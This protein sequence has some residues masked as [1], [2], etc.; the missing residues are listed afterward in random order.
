M[1][2]IHILPTDKPSR[3]A[4]S[5]DKLL[6]NSRPLSSIMYKNQ[7]IYI[8]NDEE[9]KE[10][11]TGYAYKEDVQGKVFKHFYTTNTWYKDAKKIILTTDQDLIKDGVQPIPDDFLEW[12]VKNPSCEEVQIDD[13]TDYNYQPDYKFYS[14]IIPKEEHYLSTPKPL[15]DVS[16]MK[17]DNHPDKQE[18]LEEAAVRYEK[19]DFK[20]KPTVE[21]A[22]MMIQRAFLNGAKWQQKQDKKL[23]SE[24]EV[25]SIQ[26]IS[27][28]F[29]P[30]GKGGYID[31]YLD[32]RLFSKEQPKLNF[33]EWFEQFKKKQ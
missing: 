6:L 23:Y 2:N 9:I 16:R 17:L 25:Y 26:Q 4:M 15:I 22:Q 3:L 7:N 32:Y 21:S 12:F 31:D 8:T 14:I 13:L 5:F 1:K 27:D 10:G 30:I 18:T 19:T 29:I 24:E 20:Q 33:K 28:L 11:W